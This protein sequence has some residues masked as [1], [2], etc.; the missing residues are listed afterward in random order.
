VRLGTVCSIPHKVAAAIAMLSF[1]T[2]AVTLVLPLLV[3]FGAFLVSRLFYGMAMAFIV[4][5]V[6]RFTRIG[7]MGLGFWQNVAV[8]M[9]VSLVMAATEATRLRSKPYNSN[10]QFNRRLYAHTQS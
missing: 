3:G 1:P 2:R 6:V 9:I 10:S 7:Y 8:M 5:L 4:H